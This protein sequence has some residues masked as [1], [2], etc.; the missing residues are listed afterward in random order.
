MNKFK[1]RLQEIN[2]DIKYDDSVVTYIHEEALK[3]KEYGARPIMRII[4]N[5]LEDTVTDLILEHDYEPAYTFS[6]TCENN[7]IGVN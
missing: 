4:Q 1:K 2:F 6:A 7:K 5:N 3:Q